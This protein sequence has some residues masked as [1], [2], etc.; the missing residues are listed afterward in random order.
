MLPY[1]GR[2]QKLMVVYVCVCARARVRVFTFFHREGFIC[3]DLLGYQ[4]ADQR[5]H[6]E[7]ANF[8]C[9]VPSS[10]L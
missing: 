3:L 5:C 7:D 9:Q 4:E 10:L 6:V 1:W 2:I 8:L